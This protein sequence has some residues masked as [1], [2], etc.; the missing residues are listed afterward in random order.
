MTQAPEGRLN[1]RKVATPLPLHQK[2]THFG[3]RT[4]EPIGKDVLEPVHPAVD[5]DPLTH[6]RDHGR[7]NGEHAVRDQTLHE[8]V[9]HRGDCYRSSSLADPH[10]PDRGNLTGITRLEPGQDGL[11]ISDLVV[12]DPM[13]R[14]IPL[15]GIAFALTSGLIRDN[16]ITGFP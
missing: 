12:G 13:K 4:V 3:Q 11:G 15:N 10:D 2:K 6:V 9:A 5:P 14:L 16:V 7:V 1:R 8:G